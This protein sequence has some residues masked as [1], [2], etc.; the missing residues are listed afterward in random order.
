MQKCIKCEKQVKFDYIM[1]EFGYTFCNENCLQKYMDKNP[2]KY[3]LPLHPYISEYEHVR[4][5]YIYFMNNWMD[6]LVLAD[7]TLWEMDRLITAIDALLSEYFSFYISDGD[8][9]VFHRE[10]MTYLKKLRKLQAD[11]VNW[12]PKKRKKL[13]QVELLFTEEGN[14]QQPREGKYDYP[15]RDYII[16]YN[17]LETYIDNILKEKFSMLTATMYYGKV[18]FDSFTLMENSI[19]FVYEDK[20]DAKEL[21]EA[22]KNFFNE[23]DVEIILNPAYLCDCGCDVYRTEDYMVIIDDWFF[24]YS[25][26]ERNLPKTYSKTELE[27]IV[28]S[29]I[30]DLPMPIYNEPF[31]MK[32]RR[33]CIYHDISYPPWA[34]SL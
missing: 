2:T 21:V 31:V 19:H 33:A 20:E 3:Q 4:S 29:D 5:E 1:D 8:D 10:I 15:E 30:D 6:R 14:Y 23:K 12:R 13:Y 25:C 17:H 7:D 26:E 11:I 22:C 27:K 24:D 28:S 9:G 34:D 18:E 16:C 32:V